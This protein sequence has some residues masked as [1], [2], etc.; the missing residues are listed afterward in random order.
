VFDALILTGGRARRL[1]GVDKASVMVGGL[2][3]LERVTA[4]AAGAGAARV[5]VV[6]PE[7]GGGPVAAV[8]AG[9]VRVTAPA[10]VVLAADL[11][12]L[13]PAAID[14]LRAALRTGAAVAVDGAGRD[15]T[16]CAA[17]RAPALRLALDAVGAPAGAAMRRLVAACPDVV[18]VPL[19][20]DPPPWFDCDSADDLAQARR[21]AGAAPGP[22]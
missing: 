1:G 4:A 15:Q 22:P 13:T 6:G 7:H 16:L 18:R 21:W 14:A 17:W 12:F 20:G 9:L 19:A 3:L 10:V 2:T 11:P 8:A 5:V